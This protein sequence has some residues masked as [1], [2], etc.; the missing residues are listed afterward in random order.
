MEVEI[1]K[2]V[3]AGENV[4]LHGPGG[5]GKSYTIR[6]LYKKLRSLGKKVHCTATTGIAA[7]NLSGPGIKTRTLHSWAGIGLG[8]ANV[9]KLIEK[10]KSHY[11]H[12]RRWEETQVLIIDEVSMLGAKL[13]KKLDLLARVVRGRRDEPFG[14]IRLV[15]SGDFLQLPPVKDTWLFET[16]EWKNLNLKCVPFMEP[17]R[18][19]D[20][21]YFDAL[22]RIRRGIHTE[23]DIEMLQ[24]RVTAYDEY[25]FK[26]VDSTEL[27][28]KPT[29]LY[30]RKR[31]V[32][33]Y[34]L[35]QLHS[36]PDKARTYTAED[37]YKPLRPRVRK[38]KYELMLDDAI[39]KSLVIK[40][41]A[42]VMLKANLDVDDGLVNGSRGV[43]TGLGMDYVD[44]KFRKHEIATRIM[45]HT[46]S[47]EDDDMTAMRTQ[48]PLILAWASTIHKSQGCTI[49]FAVCDIGSSVFEDGQAYVALSRVRNLDGL[50]ISDFHPDVITANADAVRYVNKMECKEVK[51]LIQFTAPHTQSTLKKTMFPIL[52]AKI[53]D[54]L[55]PNSH[56]YIY[57]D[58]IIDQIPI[59][60]FLKNQI[61]ALTIVSS[62]GK[63]PK[64]TSK[65]PVFKKNLKKAIDKGA[66]ITNV[67]IADRCIIIDWGEAS[68][69]A[70]KVLEQYPKKEY[71]DLLEI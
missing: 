36:L 32:E 12:R 6:L 47:V 26:Q 55:T 56:V 25:L 1:A 43:V 45:S 38:E 62:D 66:D 54:L 65:I 49:D 13:F 58:T 37:H 64:I 60:L 21:T 15:L 70:N 51:F 27:T 42:Q 41:G 3:L 2:K 9:L 22:L 53:A 48:I 8:D 40:V 28:I 31:D 4:L 44:V 23:E 33:A 59:M 24:K 19:D 46:W 17:K 52:E 71:I 57:A 10:V 29:L 34:N 30:S 68:V 50:F 67:F 7:L 35:N 39:K 18:Y 14:G 16:E 20:L 69:E 63:L 11:A 61:T 5:C